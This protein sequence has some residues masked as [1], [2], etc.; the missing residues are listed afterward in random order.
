LTHN[1]NK[2]LFLPMCEMCIKLHFEDVYGIEHKVYHNLSD[3]WNKEK[4]CKNNPIYS[5]KSNG[6]SFRIVHICIPFYCSILLVFI[7]SEFVR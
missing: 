3:Y 6:S 5:V 7:C 4:N 2:E 1:S